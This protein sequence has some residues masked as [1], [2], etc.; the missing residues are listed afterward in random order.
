MITATARIVPILLLAFAIPAQ[1]PSPQDDFITS[2][3]AELRQYGKSLFHVD[4]GD[5][6]WTYRTL[7]VCSSFP[8]HAFSLFER[9]STSG[10]DRF[11]VTYNLESPPAK[12]KD[13]PWQGGIVAAPLSSAWGTSSGARPDEVNLLPLFNHLL[14]EERHQLSGAVEWGSPEVAACFAAIA[15]EEALPPLG[16]SDARKS[17]EPPLPISSISFQVRSSGAI[18]RSQLVLFDKRGFIEKAEVQL[19]QVFTP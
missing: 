7:Q 4:F 16:A 3:Q 12:S 15:G 1:T 6:K 17:F 13:R 8:H 10:A 18:K 11:L 19:E 5:G 2:R 14:A 9:P